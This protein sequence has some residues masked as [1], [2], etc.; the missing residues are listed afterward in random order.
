MDNRWAFA[1][2][3]V[4]AGTGAL[5]QSTPSPDRVLQACVEASSA[6]WTSS[7]GRIC[8]FDDDT[9][10]AGNGQ[11]VLERAIVGVSVHGGYSAER[12]AANRAREAALGHRIFNPR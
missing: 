2:F 4:T 11:V 9:D 10:A 12:S 3:L 8:L 6:G 5:A 7:G 1:A